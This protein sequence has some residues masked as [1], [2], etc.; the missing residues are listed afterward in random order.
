[1]LGKEDDT[2]LVFVIDGESCTSEA[3]D[4]YHNVDRGDPKLEEEYKAFIDK[5]YEPEYS[6]RTI[7]L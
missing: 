5:D 2:D 7:R 4:V 3:S 1:M 6:I